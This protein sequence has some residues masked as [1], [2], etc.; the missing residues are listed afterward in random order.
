[1][2][3]GD[4]YLAP[5]F[6]ELGEHQGLNANWACMAWMLGGNATEGTWLLDDE[7]GEESVSLVTRKDDGSGDPAIV[8]ICSGTVEQILPIAMSIAVQVQFG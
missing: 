7:G 8:T 4:A 5:V 1:M 6:E 3:P 2:N